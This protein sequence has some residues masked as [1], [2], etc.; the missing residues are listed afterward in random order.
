MDN[1]LEKVFVWL[2]CFLSRFKMAVPARVNITIYCSMRKYIYFKIDWKTRQR[3]TKQPA[4]LCEWHDCPLVAK[5]VCYRLSPCGCYKSQLLYIYTSCVFPVI[6]ILYIFLA[7]VM[8]NNQTLRNKTVRQILVNNLLRLLL[9]L[10]SLHLGFPKAECINNYF[11]S[12]IFLSYLYLNK[13][14]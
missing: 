3:N 10:H 7:K 4:C 12:K 8:N 5:S 11:Q 14:Q 9:Y 13:P 1:I 2:H 6:F